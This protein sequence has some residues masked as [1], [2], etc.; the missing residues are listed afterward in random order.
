MGSRS[1]DVRF[2]RR[3][4]HMQATVRDQIVPL[5]RFLAV[6]VDT[7]PTTKSHDVDV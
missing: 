7:G 3:D 4:G 1:V 5:L 6:S 2:F